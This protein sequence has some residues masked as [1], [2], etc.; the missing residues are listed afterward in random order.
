MLRAAHYP[1]SKNHENDKRNL[2]TLMNGQLKPYGNVIV[3]IDHDHCSQI[4]A[5]KDN[6]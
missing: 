1:E 3:L 2:F 6:V 4:S 5:I